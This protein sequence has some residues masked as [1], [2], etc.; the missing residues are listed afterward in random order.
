MADHSLT[1]ARAIHPQ[2]AAGAARMGPLYRRIRRTGA[3]KRRLAVTI[4]DC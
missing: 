3:L 4:S 1:G 2:I